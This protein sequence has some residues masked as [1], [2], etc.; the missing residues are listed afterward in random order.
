[1]AGERVIEQSCPL[2]GAHPGEACRGPS[3]KRWRLSFHIA[4]VKTARAAK[5]VEALP[6]VGVIVTICCAGC[7]ED[8]YGHDSRQQ[9]FAASHPEWSHP[10]QPTTVRYIREDLA[11]RPPSEPEEKR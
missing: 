9:R 1:M 10:W 3:G 6:G 11:G 8:R 2:C 5:L 4:R 7:S